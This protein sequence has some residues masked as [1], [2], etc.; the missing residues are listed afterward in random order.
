MKRSGHV[1]YNFKQSEERLVARLTRLQETEAMLVEQ[2]DFL[3]PNYLSDYRH[4]REVRD[5]EIEPG[6]WSF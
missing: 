2:E 6:L 5:H 3:Y 1:Y 4:D